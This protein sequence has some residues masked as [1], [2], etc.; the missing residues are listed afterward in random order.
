MQ[1][2]PLLITQILSSI[3]IILRNCYFTEN[4]L[5]ASPIIKIKE[6]TFKECYNC[7]PVFSLKDFET[8]YDLMEIEP[9]C[10]KVM[11]FKHEILQ[12][13]NH[14]LLCSLD[15]PNQSWLF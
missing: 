10:T 6:S 1:M 8:L 14:N 11:Y 15:P 3:F 4:C 13:K 2:Q 12:I 9:Y 5:R 7:T